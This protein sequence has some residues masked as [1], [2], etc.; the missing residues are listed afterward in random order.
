MTLTS[1]LKI[2]CGTAMALGAIA[3]AA[4]ASA[5]PSC[6]PKVEGPVA[7]TATSKPY[8]PS[9]NPYAGG[10]PP[11]GEKEEEF[12]VSCDVAAGHYKT[13][14]HVTLPADPAKQSGV[15]IAEPWHPSDFW[16]VYDKA[17]NYYTRTGLV[18]VAIVATN[19]VLQNFLVKAEPERYAGLS[20]P[21]A[22]GRGAGGV[23]PDTT[24]S[25][26]LGQVGALIKSGGLPGINARKV[27]LGGMSTTGAVTRAYIAYE[28]ATPG[29]KSVFDGYFPEQS[30]LN[31]YTTPLPDI[32][33]PIVEL[34][35]ERELIV[36]FERGEPNLKYLRADGPNYRLYEV[37][38]MSHI[39]T[40]M[41]TQAD[42]PVTAVRIEPGKPECTGHPWTDFPTDMVYGAALD[43]LVQWVD[44]GVPA[45][46]VPRIQTSADN[47]TIRR[48]TYGNAMGGWR[49]SYLEVPTATY[50]GT[51]GS[52][53]T[54]PTG[55][56]DAVVADCEMIGWAEPL[57][58]TTLKNLYPSHRDYVAKVDKSTASLVGQHMLL[59]ADA[60]T[61]HAE[62]EKANI[63]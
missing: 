50:H 24:Q 46:H 14:I 19:P 22:A 15:V 44:K 59:P 13:V 10:A 33:V 26:V 51:W 28:H 32:D 35:G 52:Y 55:P 1:Y 61:L 39:A 34:Q 6:M 25:E 7:I 9:S 47:R 58:R 60:A 43:N 23:P 17:R 41:A 31:G 53:T 37:A 45:P 40:R 20:L 38:S 30:A 3:I 29:A 12:F 62:A 49:T 5:A 63:P 54:T 4:P 42:G 57:S 48:D 16:T 56:S 2:S 18:S 8:E 27:I 11:A 21:G 36:M